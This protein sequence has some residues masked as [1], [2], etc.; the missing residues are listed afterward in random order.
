[1]LALDYPDFEVVVVDNASKTDETARLVASLGD[2]RARFVREDRPGLA[3]ARNS[4]VL[5]AR[6]EIIAFTD[7]D[8]VVDKWWLRGIADGFGMGSRVA[9]VCGIVPSGE[10]QSL[11]QRYFD[12]R[13]TWARNL[14]A[15][16][17]TMKQPPPGNRLFPFGVGLYGTGANFAVTRSVLISLGGFDEGLGVGS[18]ARGGEDIDM[19][20]RVLLAGHDLAYEPAAL[21]WHRHRRDVA[22]LRS[23]VHDYGVGLGAWISKLALNPQTLRM[24]AS[25]SRS[26][27]MHGYSVARVHLPD[28][29][30][31]MSRM[32]AQLART[33]RAGMLAGPAAYARSRLHGRPAQPLRSLAR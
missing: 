28:S 33:E 21:V 4:G 27:L 3:R 31:Q 10:V 15:T 5:A 9:C 32:T 23:Q 17:Y 30:P 20:V 1:V 14:H 25:R 29:D 12:A 8:V 18:P 22:A 16:V 7:D 6:Q 26:A 11:S 24:I 2:V 19:F 13:V